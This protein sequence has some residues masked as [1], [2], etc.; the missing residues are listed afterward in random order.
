M[1]ERKMQRIID[2]NLKSFLKKQ[3]KI[4]NMHICGKLKSIISSTL[5]E[6]RKDQ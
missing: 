6:K 5:T 1:K 4:I 3:N 2:R